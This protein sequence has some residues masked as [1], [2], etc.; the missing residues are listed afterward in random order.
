VKQSNDPLKIVSVNARIE[1]VLKD[2][3][4]SQVRPFKHQSELYRKF[5]LHVVCSWLDNSPRIAQQ[6]NLMVTEDDFATAAGAK[7]V[8]VE[9]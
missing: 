5:S 6:S 9:R 2:F 1:Q 4:C 3:S 7:K 8:I